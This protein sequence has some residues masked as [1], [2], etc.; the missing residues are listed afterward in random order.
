MEIKHWVA[1]IGANCGKCKCKSPMEIVALVEFGVY[2]LWLLKV[3][4]SGFGVLGWG[5]GIICIYGI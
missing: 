3:Y 1:S 5:F 4:V 2:C